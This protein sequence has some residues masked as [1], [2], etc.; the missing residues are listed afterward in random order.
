V[1]FLLIASYIIFCINPLFSSVFI[2]LGIL[3]ERKYNKQYSA[4]LAGVFASC[5]YW[6]IP[7]GEMDLTRYLQ[8]ITILGNMNW[9][10]FVEIGLSQDFLFIKNILFYTIGKTGNYHLLPAVVI[11]ISYYLMF[12]MMTDYANRM[13]LKSS[14]VLMSLMF[15]VSVMPFI[16]LVSNIRNILAFS[17]VAFGVYREYIQNKKNILTIICYIAPCFIHI[18]SLALIL[19]RMTVI[20]SSKRKHRNAI[21]IITGIVLFFLVLDNVEVVGYL[22]VVGEYFEAFIIKANNYLNNSS[23]DYAQY[24]QKS[25][26]YKVQRL[27]FTLSVIFLL[28]IVY[29]I[30]LKSKG[31]N[32]KFENYFKYVCY[33]VIGTYPVIL[34]I[35]FRFTMV[36][37][38]FAFIVTMIRLRNICNKEWRFLAYTGMFTIMLGG[39]L[40][41]VYF[42]NRLAYIDEVFYNFAIRSIFN[43][44]IQ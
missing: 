8:Q 40:Q 34:P 43:M 9:G 24:L 32:L 44:F 26:F 3:K 28:L 41:Q 1:K 23:S 27:Y 20:I 7:R 6:V 15:L 33:I 25:L 35:Y 37:I 13:E 2:V 36:V 22:P 39:M 42:F 38:M 19:L 31:L 16:S 12:Y 14:E 17:I 5:A 4:L 11:F 10:D 21:F 29:L 18:S 30:P